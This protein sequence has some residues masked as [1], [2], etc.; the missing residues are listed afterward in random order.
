MFIFH[1][2]YPTIS[3]VDGG[4]YGGSR[5]FMGLGFFYLVAQGSVVS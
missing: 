2:G 3:A 1:L 5:A 4:L